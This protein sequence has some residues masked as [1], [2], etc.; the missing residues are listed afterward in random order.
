MVV[1][2]KKLTFIFT[3]LALCGVASA[4]TYADSSAPESAMPAEERHL[5]VSAFGGWGSFYADSI[6][7][8]GVEFFSES[9]GGPLSVDANGDGS[10]STA[11]MLG[12]NIGYKFSE[13]SPTAASWH[14]TPAIELE[15]YY[16][17]GTQSS[18]NLVNN[19]DRLEARAFDATYPMDTGVFLLNGVLNLSHGES[20]IHP[21]AGLGVGLAFVSIE[22]ATATQTDPSE[23]GINDYNSNQ[24]ASSWTFAAQTKLGV[25]YEVSER[26]NIFLEYRFLYL[27]PSDYTF[28]NTQYSTN[29]VTTDWDVSV[30]DM[31][32]NMLVVGVQFDM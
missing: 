11:H 15:S 13:L 24:N 30:G 18:N 17:T 6:N 12:M 29:V 5:Y 27:A 14:F 3:A 7:Q 26:A 25:S 10:H 21:Y 19:T 16:V 28:G 23:P 1:N 31:Y 9:E 4:S 8:S 20:K 2:F 32:Y 22:G